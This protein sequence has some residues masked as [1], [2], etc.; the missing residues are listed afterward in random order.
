M[1]K[2]ATKRSA[3]VMSILLLLIVSVL[4]GCRSSE[5]VDKQPGESN[6]ESLTSL[7]YFTINNRPD[8]LKNY[9]EM[10]AYKKLEEITGV[11]VDFKHPASAESTQQFNLMM[12]AGD[13]PDVIEWGWSGVAGGP[14]KY[15]KEK[16]IVKLNDYIDKHAPNLKKVLD[17]NPEWKKMIMTDDG[18]IYSFPFLRQDEVNMTFFGPVLRKDWLEK[19]G[20]EMPET[21]DDWHTVLTAFKEKDPNGNGK[22][23]E[24]PLLINKDNF[25]FNA[26]VGAW[27]ITNGFY[28]VDGK[29]EYGPIQPQYKEY[30][31]LMNDWYEEGL[32]DHEY[33]AT[34]SK[35]QDAKVTNNQLGAFIGYTGSSIM[36]YMQLMADKNSDFSLTG[37]TYPVHKEGEVP[38]FNQAEKAY[39]GIGAAITTSN[40]NIEETVKWLDY[41]Y[42]EEGHMLFNFGIEGESYELVEDY[43]TYTEKIIKNPE[44]V[45]MSDALAKYV[46][47]GWSGPFVQAK[48]YAEQYTSMPEQ[49]ESIKNWKKGSN[50]R[51]MPIVTPTQEDSTEYASIMNDVGTYKS[52]MINKFI[53]GEEPLSKFDEFAETIKAMG[54]D[55]AL[56]IQQA[57][58]ERYNK[59]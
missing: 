33:I 53:T 24:I 6:D 48:A 22:A 18:S 23:D 29:V 49:Q 28:Q 11:K 13:L 25:T 8:S 17:E 56:E 36:R 54:I 7:S 9:N 4:I 39:N 26:F 42:G 46:P 51:A 3:I 5:E 31:T 52:E 16:K 35:L 37:A 58:L 38:P 21:I 32:I 55:R 57:A 15:I 2:R 45:S 43:P 30:L 44:G 40:E 27:G 12:A 19:L 50:E 10:A 14:E 41:K 34:D 47:A 59:R 1:W 20:L